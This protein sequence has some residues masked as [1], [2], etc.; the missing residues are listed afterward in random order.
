MIAQLTRKKTYATYIRSFLYCF[1]RISFFVFVLEGY[2]FGYHFWADLQISDWLF[3]IRTV[4][5]GSIIAA[6]IYEL[7][8]TFRLK[9]AH[10]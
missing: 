7:S 5:V 9:N 6:F 4:I 8:D 2:K 3:Y 10:A 1:L